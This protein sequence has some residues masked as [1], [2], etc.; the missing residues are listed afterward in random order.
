MHNGNGNSPAVNSEFIPV[1]MSAP[2]MKC[3]RMNIELRLKLGENDL[4]T[5]VHL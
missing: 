4:D 2:E 5:G 1:Y 3:T